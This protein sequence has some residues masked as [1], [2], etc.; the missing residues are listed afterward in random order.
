MTWKIDQQLLDAYNKIEQKLREARKVNEKDG[1]DTRKDDILYEAEELAINYFD[2]RYCYRCKKEYP[3]LLE[4]I[5]RDH[6]MIFDKLFE[7]NNQE[8]AM[9]LSRLEPDE[10]NETTLLILSLFNNAR[11]FTNSLES[12]LF[13]DNKLLVIDKANDYLRANIINLA[14]SLLKKIPSAS[15]VDNVIEAVQALAKHYAK[16]VDTNVRCY[17]KDNALYY[18][19]RDSLGRVAI[20]NANGLEIKEQDIPC[21]PLYRK[22]MA[23]LIPSHN[24]WQLLLDNLNLA[25][26]DQDDNEIPKH[27]IDMIIKV[28][29]TALFFEH[30]PKPILCIIGDEGSGKTTLANIVKKII[31]PEDETLLKQNETISLP[32]EDKDFKALV[33]TD[34]CLAFDNL[35][36][37][38]KDISD[39]LCRLSTG[40]KITHRALYTDV[41]QS[42]VNIRRAII[43]TARHIPSQESD[44]LDRVIMFRCERIDKTKI[45][46]EEELARIGE[47]IPQV[48]YECFEAISKAL[49]IKDEVKNELRQKGLLLRLADFIVY[50]EAIARAY[51]YE[52]LYF[53]R[54][55]NEMTRVLK[56]EKIEDDEILQALFKYLDNIN[57]DFGYAK[58]VGSASELADVLKQYGVDIKAN[59]LS[60]K[61][62]DNKVILQEHGYKVRRARKDKRGSKLLIIETYVPLSSDDTSDDNYGNVYKSDD[63]GG[64]IYKSD[65]SD[66]SDDIFTKLLGQDTSNNDNKSPEINEINLENN[67]KNLGEL[68]TQSHI[69]PDKI[70]SES[71]DRQISSEDKLFKCSI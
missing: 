47:L 7:D 27:K 46:T 25:F 12:Y 8:L 36:K 32:K 55:L 10:K 3:N 41:S 61:I 22:G 38:S 52:P 13:I 4:H 40:G 2:N 35:N 63:I 28:V 31:D 69:V 21:L 44:F 54:T 15:M 64:N 5:A 34:Y 67:T 68:T 14:S 20:I 59:A 24:T 53:A 11:P 58:F 30:I 19:L 57:T 43:L 16:H 62:N 56:E 6:I 71:S 26:K 66:D 23:T 1:Y 65:D 39:L 45:R 9:I 17:F 37:I 60:R 29:T 49:R 70:S 33:K 48:R 50:A 18:D 51:G 42:S